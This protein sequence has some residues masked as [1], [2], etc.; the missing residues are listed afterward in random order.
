MV[1][2]TG[3]YDHNQPL[4]EENIHKIYWTAYLR[5]FPEYSNT[6]ENI[7]YERQQTATKQS[8]KIFKSEAY[9]FL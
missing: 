4:Y 9:F 7:L 3:K 2:Q 6:Y 1:A 5:Y 8:V